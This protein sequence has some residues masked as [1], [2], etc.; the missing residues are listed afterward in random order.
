MLM[1]NLKPLKLVQMQ[2]EEKLTKII[3]FRPYFGFGGPVRE[4]LD[5]TLK[6][7]LLFFENWKVF[8]CLANGNTAQ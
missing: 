6:K 7:F 8:L 1:K 2:S 4:T 5:Q 3:G